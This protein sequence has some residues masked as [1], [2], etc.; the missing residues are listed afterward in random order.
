MNLGLLYSFPCPVPDIDLPTMVLIM[1][2]T[3]MMMVGIM[4]MVRMVGIS[5]IIVISS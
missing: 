2:A 3:V 4:G 1:V 5:M